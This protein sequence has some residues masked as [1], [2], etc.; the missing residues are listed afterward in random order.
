M[1]KTN[2]N[3]NLKIGLETKIIVNES[4]IINN[5]ENK[6]KEYKYLFE[7][8]SFLILKKILNH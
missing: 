4:L 6:N 8:D 5:N 2:I 1:E 7:E 3:E